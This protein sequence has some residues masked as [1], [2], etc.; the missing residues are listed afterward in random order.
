[1][2]GFPPGLELAD[3]ILTA[4][5]LLSLEG[6]FAVRVVGQA[7]V[8]RW[9]PACLPPMSEWYS[10]RIPYP[11]L[12]VIQLVT[13]VGMTVVAAIVARGRL[14]PVHERDSIGTLLLAIAWLYAGAMVVRYVL[15]MW[16]HPDARWTGQTIPIV[17][18]IVLAAWLLVLGSY[19]R[20]G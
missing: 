4:L 12:L 15:R 17:F 11:P 5:I 2:T 20:T 13:L 1:M 19:V 3:P 6:V 14:P 10:G 16:H 7:I 8:A 9:A 18:H